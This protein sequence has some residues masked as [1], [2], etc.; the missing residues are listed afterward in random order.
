MI[1][2]SEDIWLRAKQRAE[3]DEA[4][5][6]SEWQTKHSAKIEKLLKDL[7]FN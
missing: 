7:K 4:I 5:T 1:N 2:Q 3:Q 6:L